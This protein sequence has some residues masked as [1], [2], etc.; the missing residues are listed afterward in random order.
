MTAQIQRKNRRSGSFI[1]NASDIR[2]EKNTIHTCSTM[3]SRPNVMQL[4][5]NYAIKFDFKDEEEEDIE[6]NILL[7]LLEYQ[8]KENEPVPYTDYS[9]QLGIPLQQKSL[10]PVKST[11][12]VSRSL[13]TA[14]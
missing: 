5:K 9:F 1:E 11:S 10:S 12:N 8:H 2:Q 14:D 6:S 7:H 4:N 13:Q 3:N